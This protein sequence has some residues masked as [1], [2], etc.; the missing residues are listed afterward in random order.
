M[1]QQFDNIANPKA[2]RLTT[3]K[4]IIDDFK[5]TGLDCFVSGVSAGGT[6]TGVS[7]EL[8]KVFTDIKIVAVEPDASPVFR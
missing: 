5:A 6:I 4:D 1:P 7:E 8:K 2:H 3:A